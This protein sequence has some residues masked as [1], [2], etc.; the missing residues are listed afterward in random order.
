MAPAVVKDQLTID[1]SLTHFENWRRQS[2]TQ[3]EVAN[4]VGAGLAQAI[5]DLAA[6]NRNQGAA[7]LA[8]LRGDVKHIGGSWAQRQLFKDLQEYY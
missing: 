6:G 2:T 7:S 4:T 8:R 3:G 5:V 1:K